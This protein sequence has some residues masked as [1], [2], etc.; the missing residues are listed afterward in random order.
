[1][2]A[3]IALGIYWQALKLWWRGAR[4]YSN[5]KTVSTSHE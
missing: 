5:P 4:F 2:T 3:K 1:M